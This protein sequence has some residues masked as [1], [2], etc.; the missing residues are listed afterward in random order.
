MIF[1]E[2]ATNTKTRERRRCARRPSMKKFAHMLNL[3]LTVTA[4]SARF[5]A[6]ISTDIAGS[7]SRAFFK[8]ARSPPA[9]D[10]M[11]RELTASPIQ[12]D[13]IAIPIAVPV[14]RGKTSPSSATVVGKTGA[15]A[16]PA[17][18]GKYP[19][20]GW[21]SSLQHRERQDRHQDGSGQRHRKARD[22]NQNL[23]SHQTSE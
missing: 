20:D 17:K 10:P 22:R 7:T 23:R 8:R 5:T 11:M 12:L 13:V 2:S 19:R 21:I 4:R 18:K 16:M 15:M 1:T 3:T 14:M 9:M 6:I